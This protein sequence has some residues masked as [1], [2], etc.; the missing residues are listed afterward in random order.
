MRI[1]ALV[2]FALLAF[3]CSRAEPAAETRSHRPPQYA[4]AVPSSPLRVR[5]ELP[6]GVRVNGSVV[7]RLELINTGDSTVSFLLTDRPPAFD[8]R[9]MQAD[10]SVV[11]RRLRTGFVRAVGTRVS[12]RAGEKIPFIERWDLTDLHRNSVLPGTYYVQGLVYTDQ[13]LSWTA[14]EPLMVAGHQ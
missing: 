3:G 8:F 14:A 10:G 1:S 9:I 6:V 2:V 4:A 13:G 11:W 7:L 5:L 12:L